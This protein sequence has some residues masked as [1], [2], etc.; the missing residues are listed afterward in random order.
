MIPLLIGVALL[1]TAC[2]AV[3]SK[4]VEYQS[5]CHDKH[6]TFVAAVECLRANASEMAK[7]RDGDLVRLYLAEAGLLAL[8]VQYNQLDGRLAWYELEKSL[9]FLQQQS[10]QRDGLRLQGLGQGLQNASAAMQRAIPP[11]RSPVVCH[12]M[13]STMICN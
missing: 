8:K 6:Q 7:G 4:M 5:E 2:A 12:F 3:G 11:P 10:N 13:G 1:V 9:A